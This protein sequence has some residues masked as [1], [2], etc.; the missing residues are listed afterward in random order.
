MESLFLLAVVFIIGIPLVAI[1][2]L[3]R[4]G[5]LRKLIDSQYNE[6]LRTVSK[7]NQEMADLRSSLA[8][9]SSEL[10]R[11]KT[12]G[13]VTAATDPEASVQASALI[14]PTVGIAIAQ[15]DQTAIHIDPRPVAPVGPEVS[16]TASADPEQSLAPVTVRALTVEV[17]SIVSTLS[18]ESE[19]EP[20]PTAHPAAVFSADISASLPPSGAPPPKNEQLR[21]APHS[22]FESYEPSHA[23]PP[24]KSF[25]ERLRDVLP[26]E[27]VLGMNLFVKIGMVLLVLGFALLGRVAL[28]AMGPAGKV[29]LIYAAGAALLG[30][31]IWLERKERY[32]LIGRTG[33][34]GGWALLFFT[35]YAMY[36]VPA[37]HVL[38]SQ[39]MDCVLL[40]GVAVGMV[41]HTLQYKSQLVT[42][43]A[44]L[45]AFS[46]VALSQDT[47]YS[48]AAGVIL[49]FAIVVI[50]LREGWYE[51]E[52][53]GILAS[54]CN[55]FYWLYKLYPLG[56][57]GHP[58]PEFWPSAI[59]LVLYWL[60]FR[61]SYVS[62]N[63]RTPRD[64]R[65]ST[66]A[67]LL[68]PALLLAVMKFQSTRP[69]LAFYALLG[70][71]AI[72]FFFGQLPTTRRRRPAFILLT[73]LG[74]AL[75]LGSVPFKFS[76]NSIALLW[77]IA[78]EMLIVAGI[79]QSE[80]IFRRLG[81][82]TGVFTGLLVVYEA[83]GIVELR[84]H[85]E[86][87]L[88]QNGILLLTCAALFYLNSHF[89]G[90][91][92]RQFFEDFDDKLMTAHSYIGCATA[93]IGVWALLTRDWTALGW[94]AVMIAAA[95]G[96][97]R[98]VDKRLTLQAG[99]FAVAVVVRTA[100]QNC[101]FDAPYPQ[102]PTAR[103]ITLPI[104]SAVFYLT[105]A[106]LSKTEETLEDFATPLRVAMLWVGTSLLVTM[107]W[108]DIAPDWVALVW[109]ALAV[110][111]VLISHRIQL[112]SFCYQEHVVA[113][114]VG[115]QLITVNLNTGS[116]TSRYASFLACA[117]ALYSISRL[118]TFIDAP[119]R[120]FVAWAHTCG[121]TALLTALAWHESA[122][123]WIAVI[124]AVFA[125]ALAVFDR[126]FEVEELPYQAHALAVLAVLRV[127]T[128]NLYTADKWHNIDL[129][130]ITVSIV[131][132]AM[133]AMCRWVRIPGQLR[134]QDFHHLYS[135]AGSLL[136][137][138]MLWS[139]LQPLSVAL[140]LAIFG[141]V[142]FEWGLLRKVR[143]LRLQG[144]LAL[145][146]AFAR[147]FFINLTAAR[148]P[149]ESVSPALYT[150]A[151]IALIFFFIWAQLQADK[152][153]ASTLGGFPT[154]LTSLLISVP[155]LS[156]P[157]SIFKCLQS[158]SSW[159]GPCW[160]C[161]CWLPLFCS[162][163]KCF[164]N[165]V[166]CCSSES[167]AAASLITSLAEAT[168][169]TMVGMATSPSSRWL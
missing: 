9:V 75:M 93:F 32:R 15:A 65:F 4:V 146:A 29:A 79:I 56:M 125:L 51:L 67:G 158:G 14:V 140:G 16:E 27:E 35:T 71:G 150:V 119:Y 143:Q 13:P 147:I 78:A 169:Q 63:I 36:H 118:C 130:L 74:T 122:A 85:S 1:V 144:Y 167:W 138:W 26:L 133:Y 110:A 88:A 104:L 91:K 162:T 164:C 145:T 128:L 76:G 55:H 161:S 10:D 24:R 59:I 61:I 7:L 39:T 89:I 123:L 107:A 141:L 136:A 106:A 121:A 152:T 153:T 149:G 5:S 40:L 148:L 111:L 142:L 109:M 117:A 28:I 6:N 160:L 64:E 3:V 165:R 126:M 69:E 21:P 113:M 70:L 2:A 58:F 116:T 8:R 127:V 156:Q 23:K 73:I 50:A 135:W 17:R 18:A 44:F 105:A 53:F 115:F 19:S 86:Q 57:A 92:W 46:T 102:H 137:A 45:L 124:W 41:A 68:N 80:V 157:C 30:G 43:L 139:E 103:L 120:R 114:L 155:G 83:K 168:S 87:L 97:R 163:R 99:I 82:L 77:M 38:N 34:G 96:A 12:A 31:G 66:A 84:Q 62:R 47:V 72:E 101:H 11:Q 48:L 54:Y 98:L 42:G 129:R 166:R 108:L 132:A 22:V 25:A 94:A 154:C 100:L 60:T 90:Q 151:P 81:L 159:P 33:I 112:A 134:E 20:E 95:A 131:V 37:M 52:I 49:A